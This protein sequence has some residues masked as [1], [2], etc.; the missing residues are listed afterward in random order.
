MSSNKAKSNKG[1][2]GSVNLELSFKSMREHSNDPFSASVRRSSRHNKLEDPLS[3]FKTWPLGEFPKG[4]PRAGLKFIRR[5]TESKHGTSNR[6]RVEYDLQEYEHNMWVHTFKNSS[7]Y[8]AAEGDKDRM[9]RYFHKDKL[10]LISIGTEDSHCWKVQYVSAPASAPGASS[11]LASVQTDTS[12]KRTPKNKKSKKGK[13]HKKSKKGKKKQKKDTSSESGEESSSSAAS[14]DGASVVS[15]GRGAT[16]SY[17]TP[18]MT[19]FYR[20]LQALQKQYY[21]YMRASIVL[22][23]DDGALEFFNTTID[24]LE[25]SKNLSDEEKYEP[26]KRISW[27]DIKKI[28]LE[29]ICVDVN[30]NF[31]YRPLLTIYRKDKQTRFD[32]CNLIDDLREG[33]HGFKQGYEKIGT[34][35]FVE[36]L[37]DWLIPE[38]EQKPILKYFRETAPKKYE[39]EKD[40][41]K[42]VTL[43]ELIEAINMKMKHSDFTDTVFM[44]SMCPKGTAKLLYKQSYVQGLKDRLDKLEKAKRSPP[45]NPNGANTRKKRN[46]RR[47]GKTPK[48]VTTTQEPEEGEIEEEPDFLASADHSDPL[49]DESPKGKTTKKG[50][51]KKQKTWA[52]IK[53]LNVGLG[54]RFHTTKCDANKQAAALKVQQEKREKSGVKQDDAYWQSRMCKARPKRKYKL[55]EYGPHHCS[56]C[57]AFGVPPAYAQKHPAKTCIYRYDGELQKALKCNYVKMAS[58]FSKEQIEKAKKAVFT[59]RKTGKKVRFA[60]V[61]NRVPGGEVDPKAAKVKRDHRDPDFFTVQYAVF[62]KYGAA[63]GNNREILTS[64]RRNLFEN[65]KLRKKFAREIADSPKSIRQKVKKVKW[66]RLP[67]HYEP[68]QEESDSDQEYVNLD[69]KL[70]PKELADK[71]YP[72]GTSNLLP[73]DAVRDSGYPEG[74]DELDFDQQSRVDS[75]ADKFDHELR[76]ELENKQP[77]MQVQA[78]MRLADGKATQ[79]EVDHLTVQIR[80]EIHT[81]EHAVTIKRRLAEGFNY[82]ALTRE[83][84]EVLS[85]AHSLHVGRH[86]MRLKSLCNGRLEDDGERIYFVQT[87]GSKRLEADTRPLSPSEYQRYVN[88]HRTYESKNAE[89]IKLRAQ[90]RNRLM[91]LEAAKRK[92]KREAAEK[93]NKK[94]SRSQRRRKDVKDA[95]IQLLE[96]ESDS[97]PEN[98]DDGSDPSG[99]S[100][101]D[102]TVTSS[103]CSRPH[104]PCTVQPTV[105]VHTRPTGKGRFTLGFDACRKKLRLQ[106][107]G[108]TS[109]VIELPTEAYIP[110]S[111]YDRTCLPVARIH[112]GDANL[113]NSETPN[114]KTLLSEQKGFKLLQAFMKYRDPQGRIKVGRVQLDT[115]SAVSYALPGVSVNRDWRPW[116]S[117]YAMGIKRETVKLGTPTS[118]TVMRKGEPVV[119][120]T[121]DPYSKLNNGCV[122]LLGFEAIQK[123]GIDLNYHARFSSHKQIKYLDNL[124]ETIKEC[125]EM[126]RE[127][128]EEHAQPLSARDLCRIS[129]LSERVIADY[130]S[131]HPSDYERKKIELES[132]DISPDMSEADRRRLMQVILKYRHVFAEYS[133][134]LPPPMKKVKPHKFKLKPNSESRPVPPPK[135][136]PAKRKL[137]LDWLDWALDPN[138]DGSPGLV[139][140]A[141]GAAYASRLHLAAKYGANTPKSA[142]PDGIRIT[143]AGVEV[144]DTLEKSIPTYTDAWEQLYKVAA[145]KYKFSADGLKQYWSIPL[146]E[147]SRDVTAFWTPRGLYRFTRLVMGT[148]NA[149]TVAQNAYTWAMHNL[150]PKHAFDQIANFADDFMGGA[151]TH[152]DLI[153]LFEEFLK[154]SSDA[155]ITINPSKVRIGY[156]KEQFYGYVVNEGKISPA[157]RNLDPVKNMVNPTNRSELRSVMGVFNQF[158]GAGFIKD[159][160]KRGS[161]ASIINELASTKVPFIWTNKHTKAL[162]QLKDMVLG[163]DLWLYAPRN[164]LP[165]HLETDGSEDGW[166]AVL[167]QIID[168]ERRVI[169][170]W[171]KK[172]A[173]EAW[174]KKPPYHREAKAWM[175]GMELTIPIAMFNK[176]A[177]ECYTDHSPLTWVKHTSGKG[178]VSQFIIDKLSVIDFNMHYI[179]G[180]DNVVADAL[181]RFPMLGPKTLVREGLKTALDYLLAALVNTDIDAT[182]MWLDARKDSRHLVESIF[183]WREATQVAEVHSKPIRMESVSESNI[184][185]LPY[186]FGIWAPPADKITQQCHAAFLKDVPFAFLVPGDLVKYIPLNQEGQCDPL[187]RQR[188]HEAGK[189]SLLDPGLVWIIHKA[190]QVRQVYDVERQAPAIT[191]DGPIEQLFFEASKPIEE[192]D[193]EQLMAHVQSSVLTPPLEQCPDRQAWIREQKACLIPQ[194]WKGKAHTAPDGLCYIKRDDGPNRIIVPRTLQIPLVKWKHYNMCHA[195]PKKVYNQLAKRYYWKGMSTMCHKLCNDCR[196]CAILK[197]RMNLAHKHF[198]AKLF[199]TPRTAYG[200]D[201]YGVRKNAKGFC[202]ILGIIDLSTGNLVLKAGKSASAAHV[203]NTLFHD[204][205]LRKGVPLLFHSD[206]AQ[207]FLGKAMEALSR[208]LGIK[209]TSTLAHN[210]KSNAK[211]ERVWEFVGRALRAMT[212]EQYAQFE[213]HLPILEHVWNNTP[214]S[215]T[216]RTP[217]EAEHGMPMRGVAESLMENPPVAGLPADARDLAA[218]AIS[219]KAHAQLLANIK[220][221]E[222]TLAAKALNEKGFAKVKYQIGDRVTFYL[223]P[224]QNQAQAMGKNPKHL[225]QY[226]GPGT[227]VASLSDK[228][229]A[230]EIRWNGRT[231]Q[232]NVMH[233][234]KYEPSEHVLY[235]QRVMHDN[236]IMAGSYVAVLDDS[237]DS[238]YHIAKVTSITDTVTN[239]HYMGTKSN[240]LRS[241][242]WQYLFHE[243]WSGK[244]KRRGNTSQRYLLKNSEDASPHKYTGR[245]ETRPM[246]DSLIVLPNL[247]FTEAMRLGTHTVRLLRELP[248]KHHV[249]LSTWQ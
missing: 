235:E 211:M 26:G 108:S 243:K 225:L 240:Q 171:S 53:C 174:Q 91:R 146:D 203:T 77:S 10:G 97:A 22:H 16:K 205:V 32:W 113:N 202:Q 181:S 209:Q 188:L 195:G 156:T 94:L 20:D 153:T 121:N 149:S 192:P 7:Y 85:A 126:I 55:E 152:G 226:A 237:E 67:K 109:R 51:G 141:D 129:N 221:V 223:P 150:L 4:V 155:G 102:A 110:A 37:W 72:E 160:G 120:D 87:F 119:I 9:M 92:R 157:A 204:I 172:W 229:S 131:A 125:N 161:P 233:M 52:C 193:L 236:V 144:N 118:F 95:L 189:I 11:A 183:Q 105:Y 187:V 25:D 194:I 117:Q 111:R 12:G 96:S 185:K 74:R 176:H 135:F 38:D 166:G 132:L 50:G 42:G 44:R 21:M 57:I 180:K 170:M 128:L 69:G 178:P 134:T 88:M 5:N 239:L 103:N 112:F 35:D 104:K 107:K 23:M 148:K 27:K 200:A 168:G 115:Q 232:R 210:P 140:P 24:Q 145:Y 214:D 216:G 114:K 158:S 228:G 58:G 56:W 68:E 213:L 63:K 227:I 45:T 89:H 13:K 159:Y 60:G 14:A 75:L 6:S 93:A 47:K 143:W 73:R 66:V 28:I 34:R 186:T 101:K 142:P 244:R 64:M 49:A 196:L 218:I 219:A 154:M 130:L 179:K 206:A 138:G 19:T 201:Y 246:G 39:T 54:I 98:S 17:K 40:M 224:T 197:Q 245:I 61:T 62:Q 82:H 208:T 220:A 139:E 198:R 43:K 175:N 212:A 147:A 167:F 173:T 124:D 31:Y 65:A 106:C 100:D 177:V 182:K 36:K 184:R 46:Q 151:D 2:A 18:V 169:K 238:F 136:G 207:A 199:C 81:L 122:A 230:W 15:S 79:E 30:G 165:L 191:T 76:E 249:Y 71:L 83:E 231:Y 1:G 133:N 247:G 234:R 217:F 3:M 127:L 215:L 48:V 162:E 90:T 241:A 137:I 41:L 116:E 123:L 29:D 222:R 84:R 248:Q 59:A 86:Q 33:I 163:R 190:P 70:M 80:K 242:V 164:D 8:S 78:A 99:D